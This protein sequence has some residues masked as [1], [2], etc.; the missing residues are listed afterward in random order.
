MSESPRALIWSRARPVPEGQSFITGHG[1]W[2]VHTDLQSVTLTTA[3]LSI[4]YDLS[5]LELSPKDAIHSVNFL[6][7]GQSL[8][9]HATRNSLP[10]GFV[11]Q[12]DPPR[13]PLPRIRSFELDTI[14]FH[15]SILAAF[16][17]CET[18]ICIISKEGITVHNH[19]LKHIFNAMAPV[20]ACCYYENVVLLVTESP[21]SLAITKWE[22]AWVGDAGERQIK[23]VMSMHIPCWTG[24]IPRQLFVLSHAILLV[25]RPPVTIIKVRQFEQ[26]V[27]AHSASAVDDAV[28]TVFDDALLVFDPDS[29]EFRLFDVFENRDVLIGAPFQGVPTVGVFKSCLALSDAT[30]YDIVANY[31]QLPPEGSAM[32]AALFRRA[33]G[34]SAAARL[35][36]K[37]FLQTDRIDDL[38]TLITSVGPYARSPLAQLRFVH[39]IQFSGVLNPHF[40]MLA[41][42]EYARILGAE[43]IPDAKI[44]L[45]ETMFHRAVRFTLGN[46]LD[47][48]QPK[49]TRRVMQTIMEGGIKIDSRCAD[50]I[51]DYARACWVTGNRSEAKRTLLRFKLDADENDPRIE[52]LER[53]MS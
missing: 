37:Q 12:F 23:A 36:G 3:E 11:L 45:I 7:P 4:T 33:N 25:C 35:L 6:Q 30:V 41:L 15:Q 13:P 17:P 5:D 31:D 8:F 51:L 43:T 20:S 19:T 28:F 50:N 52:D 18:A 22:Y 38:R 10:T 44:P 49:L 21:T 53:L 2:T 27:C 9:I 40:I 39:A 24:P 16:S 32:I 48:W 34:A 42:L 14:M 46:L 26:V 47:E 29:D 1:I